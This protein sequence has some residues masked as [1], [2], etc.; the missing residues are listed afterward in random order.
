MLYKIMLWGSRLSVLLLAISFVVPFLA[1]SSFPIL[2]LASLAVSPLILLNILFLVYWLFRK[3]RKMVL[4]GLVLLIAYLHF[5]PFIELSSHGDKTEYRDSLTILS[6]NVRLF[7]AYEKDVDS[8]AVSGVISK[9]IAEQKPDVIAIQEY[10]KPNSA[11]FSDYPYRFVH[12]H[13]ENKL[14]HAI[15][16][17]Y[18]I[19]NQGAFDFKKT[20]NNSIYA[21]IV[22]GAD[23]IR[24]YNLHLQ[25]LGILPKVGYLQDGDT[26]VIRSRMSSAFVK[27]E[28]QL[29][30]I[31]SHK[32]T[33]PY[34][35]VMCGDFN[36]TPFS[37]VYRQAKENMKDSFL[38]R[39][40]GI[41]TTFKFD[42]YPVRIDYIFTSPSFEVVSFQTLDNT[43]SDHSPV[44]ATLGWPVKAD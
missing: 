1:P 4:S 15:F 31:L 23:T 26:E 6:Y 42:F 36:N 3:S 18:P 22:K 11:D 10:Y 34:P 41:G 32:T 28:D 17:K 40:N 33:S 21:D 8:I 5:G 30:K 19:V 35:V 12:F 2:S 20:Y 27:Q 16:S 24:V 13:D 29:K 39:G 9:M 37:Y 43:F 38:E 25:S 7:N 44:T 14:G